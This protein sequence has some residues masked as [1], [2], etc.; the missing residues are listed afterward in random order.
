MDLVGKGCEDGRWTEPIQGH[1]QRWALLLPVLNILVLPP[2]TLVVRFR[3][4]SSGGL[5]YYL[6]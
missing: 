2:E 6:C 1:A 5:C 4:T 3:D